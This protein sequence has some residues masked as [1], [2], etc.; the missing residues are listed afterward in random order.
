VATGDLTIPIA[1]EF[2]L[3]RVREAVEL[4]ASRHAKGKVVVTL[5]E[6]R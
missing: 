6:P 3:D 5:D 2:G 1:A 4:Q